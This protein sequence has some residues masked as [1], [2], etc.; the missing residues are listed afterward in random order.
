MEALKTG[1]GLVLKE[2]RGPAGRQPREQGGGQHPTQSNG[3][4]QNTEAMFSA[5]MQ[6]G[7]S[8]RSMFLIKNLKEIP[9][10]IVFQEDPLE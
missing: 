5:N 1:T 7:T 3:P 8:H 4:V 10:S 9:S 2:G 6:R